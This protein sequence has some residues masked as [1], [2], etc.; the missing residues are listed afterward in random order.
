MKQKILIE[1]ENVWKIYQMGQVKVPALRGV[2]IKIEK[3]DFVAIIGASGSGKSTIMNL[4][5]CLD[6]P[7]KGRVLLKSQ[8]VSKMDESD[9][10]SRRGNTIG[11]VFQQYNL[12]PSMTAFDNVLLPM[13][14]QDMPGYAASERAKK[15]LSLVGLGDKLFNKPTQLSGGEQQRVSIARS[16]ACDPEIILADEPTG[17][18][19]SITGKEIMDM[20]YE[21]WKKDGKTIIIVTHDLHLAKYARTIIE[22]KDGKVLK[23]YQNKKMNV[24]RKT[25]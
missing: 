3:G 8:D 12:I 18:L 25:K 10:A 4:I 13:D 7:T 15:L 5:G 14:F 17:A 9:L 21:L 6:I 1:L 20:L 22:L 16:L 24:R 2:S 23:K 19:D 11:F